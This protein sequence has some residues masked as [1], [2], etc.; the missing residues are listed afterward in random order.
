MTPTSVPS[1][2]KERQPLMSPDLTSDERLLPV[3]RGKVN[4][5]K[6]TSY[7]MTWGELRDHLTSHH[8]TEETVEEWRTLAKDE[9]S[10][11]K[12][13]RGGWIGGTMTGG[14]SAT[15]ILSRSVLTLDVDQ[16]PPDILDRIEGL[17]LEAVAHPTHTAG[18]W[19]VVFPLARDVSQDEYKELVDRARGW[20]PGI[21]A[22]SREPTLMMFWPTVSSDASW[23]PLTVSGEWL[24]PDDLPSEWAHV[25]EFHKES[26][27]FLSVDEMV[28]AVRHA[29]VGERNNTLRDAVYALTRRNLYNTKVAQKLYSAAFAAG[30][31]ENEIRA[32]VKSAHGGAMEHNKAELEDDFADFEETEDI[33]PENAEWEL[34]TAS[35]T[36]I[37][38]PKEIWYDMLPLG[39]LV[40]LSGRGGVGKSTLDAYLAAKASRGEMDGDLEGPLNVIMVLDEDDWQMDTVPRLKAANADMRYVHKWRVRRGKEW[41]NVPSFPDDISLLRQAIVKINAKVIILDVITSMMQQGLDPNNQADVRKL[42]NP[43]LGL[44]QETES[45]IIVV[46]HWRKGSGRLSDMISGSGAYRDTARCVWMVAVDP[47]TGERRI[48]IDKYNRSPMQGQSFSFRLKSVPIEGWKRAD[49]SPKTIGVVDDFNESSTGVEDIIDGEVAAASGTLLDTQGDLEAVTWLERLLGEEPLNWRDISQRGKEERFAER[50][51][52]RARMHLECE[53]MNVNVPGQPGR[54]TTLW[55]LPGAKVSYTPPEPQ[56]DFEAVDDIELLLM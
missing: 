43:L 46:N 13:S 17:G 24:N 31:T 5:R 25:E 2:Q 44:A 14:R 10:S 15:D 29:P 35:H 22:A 41:T 55:R 9:R 51:L 54:G 56:D 53:T 21:D 7:P 50:Q 11:I 37:V 8:P 26:I 3:A 6:W 12:A 40:V 34:I 47:A 49:G 38:E 30:L 36:E 4:H 27:Y 1:D 33:S 20:L 28:D 48:T 45:T 52:K 23:E 42:L 16:P 32:T 39:A 18:R 19:R